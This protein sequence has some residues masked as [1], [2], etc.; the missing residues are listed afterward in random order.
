MIKRIGVGLFCLLLL[1]LPSCKLAQ[2]ISGDR[3]ITAFKSDMAVKSNDGYQFLCRFIRDDIDTTDI[4]IISPEETRG[5]KYEYREGAYQV[6]FGSK[7]IGPGNH[8][9]PQSSFTE[10]LTDILSCCAGND[11]LIRTYSGEETTTFNGNCG[12]GSFRVT[13]NKDTGYI[14]KIYAD[15]YNIEYDFS[16][17]SG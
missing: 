14:E 3:I 6:S 5:L 15:G 12:A 2:S 9:L 11:N 8:V 7:S 13:V 17:Q 16:N 1:I 4:E 10:I